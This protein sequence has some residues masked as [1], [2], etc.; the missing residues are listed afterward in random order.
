MLDNCLDKNTFCI[1]INEKKENLYRMAYM[2]VKNSDDALDIVQE[3]IYKAYLSFE[4]LKDLKYFNTWITR[5]VINC[6]LDYIRKR[7]KLVF[8]E[9]NISSGEYNADN[10]E[11]VIDLYNAVDKLKGN[12][13]TI[14]ILKY[15]EGLTINNIAEILD[16]PV[17]KVKNNLHRALN[18]L[19]LELKEEDY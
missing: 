17:S 12:S 7:K 9:E 13:K 1:L 15:F 18:E 10:K 16:C 3:A 14:V 8:L 5:I 4:K 6:S 2:H 11:E 19:R